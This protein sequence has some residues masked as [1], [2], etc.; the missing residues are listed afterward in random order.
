MLTALLIFTAAFAQDAPTYT[1]LAIADFDGDGVEDTAI[2]VDGSCG[3]IEMWLSSADSS[4]IG[5]TR[6]REELS[7]STLVIKSPTCNN[8]F[9][10]ALSV[11]SDGR[12]SWLVSGTLDTKLQKIVL[13]EFR[14]Y[15]SADVKEQDPDAADIVFEPEVE[16]VVFGDA[17]DPCCGG[18]DCCI[19]E[20]SPD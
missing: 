18:E 5:S 7:P 15:W 10:Q 4:A 17:C 16:D 1:N 3:T 11:A 12:T 8:D 20:C 6:T 14:G 2:G 9:G 13:S 19:G